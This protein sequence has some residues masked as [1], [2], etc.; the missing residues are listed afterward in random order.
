MHNK[1]DAITISLWT[2]LIGLALAALPVSAAL[3][4]GRTEFVGW[5]ALTA[6]PVFFSLQI[7]SITAGVIEHKSKSGMLAIAIATASIGLVLGAAY[8]DPA[9]YIFASL[10]AWPLFVAVPIVSILAG[11]TA[12][13]VKH[14]RTKPLKPML[15][16]ALTAFVLV[17]WPLVRLLLG[18]PHCSLKHVLVALGLLLLGPWS[19]V[20]LVDHFDEAGFFFRL[21]FAIGLTV[22]II[23]F[24]VM[25]L[26]AKKPRRAAI[27]LILFAAVLLCCFSIGGMGLVVWGRLFR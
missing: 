16:L 26:K 21:P 19:I 18:N 12:I 22:A 23:G 3:V 2:S 13:D 10:F 20:A 5:L 14:G 7:S 8:L 15:V 6:A 24:S 27:L 1:E 25:T 9:R 11:V 4:W 17:A